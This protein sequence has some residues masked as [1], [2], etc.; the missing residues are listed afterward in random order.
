MIVDNS[1]SVGGM[2]SPPTNQNSEV[3]SIRFE[4][5]VHWTPKQEEAV[6][7]A[8]GHRYT[9]YGGSRGPGKSYWLRWYQ[10]RFL[11]MHSEV[12]G[13]RVGLFCEDYPSLKDRHI[14]KIK[15]EFPEWLGELRDSQETGLGFHL[16]ERYGGGVLAMRNLD[17]PA[18][19][20][21]AEF[22]S[23]AVDELTKNTIE[24]FNVL[25]GSLRWPGVE[26]VKFI[27]ATNPGGIG[28]G[29]VKRIWI[30]RQFPREMEAIAG[31][32]AFVK[33]LPDD[34]PYLAKSYWEM[35]ETL[36]P[37][38]AKAWRHGE[39]DV[40]EGQVFDQWVREKH[41]CKPFEIPASWS[42]W[43]AVDWGYRSPFCCLWMAQDPDVGRVY[44]YREVYEV[45]MTDRAQAKMIV[46]NTPR[47][48]KINLT[49]ADP[50]MWTKRSMED[51]TFSTADEYRAEGV[52]LVRADNHRM[53]GKRK[54]DELLAPL[55]DGRPGLVVFET[56]D[57]LIRTL[58]ALPYD[59]IAIEDVDSRAEDHAYDTLKYGLSRIQGGRPRL[60]AGKA[61]FDPLAKLLR[62]RQGTLGADF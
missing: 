9:L 4:E 58:P 47:E 40:F 14:S 53:T 36:P 26:D 12:R 34:N 6:M 51:T 31:E 10:L 54:I 35:L 60:P 24:T 8:D 59:K 39:W 11:L 7:A 49:Y 19:Y 23:I 44:V 38:L 50:S 21:S 43:R 3:A 46:A 16:R 42:K 57:N 28:H 27:G 55:P 17:D 62:G 15:G 41:V 20:M 18:K 37:A 25:R 1:V 5:I 48:E 56:C 32:F 61:V 13:L 22:A 33:A 29:W 2:G 30:D 52:V 45:G